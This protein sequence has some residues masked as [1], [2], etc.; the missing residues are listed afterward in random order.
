MGS[1]RAGYE[2]AEYSDEVPPAAPPSPGATFGP[3]VATV[4]FDG[5]DVPALDLQS[6]KETGVYRDSI[7]EDGAGAAVAE[8]A[9]ALSVA[10]ETSGNIAS[11][12]CGPAC[13]RR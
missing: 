12:N 4:A 13:S 2:A 6:Q 3:N 10:C 7:Q 8:V 9:P 11:R 1:G 5:L